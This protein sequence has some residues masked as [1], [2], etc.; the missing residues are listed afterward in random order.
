MNYQP[1]L[2][3]RILAINGRVTPWLHK[4][5]F[6]FAHDE[7]HVQTFCFT[8]WCC[9]PTDAVDAVRRVVDVQEQT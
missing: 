4:M 7:Q 9:L 1:Q 8:S 5:A 3:S 6:L 2:V